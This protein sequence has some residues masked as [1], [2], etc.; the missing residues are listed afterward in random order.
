MQHLIN[1]IETGKY[2]N[3]KTTKDKI[4]EIVQTRNLISYMN[5][6]K[7]NEFIDDISEIQDL[8]IKYKTLFDEQ[9]PQ[10]YWT[11]DGDE[12]FFYM[13]MATIEWFKVLDTITITQYIGRL[14]EP[15]IEQH[16][17][18]NEIEIILKKYSIFYEYDEDEKAF[19]IYGY[20]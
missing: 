3:K 10:C 19:V 16:S 17:V 13:D 4:H 12:H 11:I 2:R 6:T 1:E 18:K 5:K 14:I 8:P 9:E 7:W 20:K 15:K